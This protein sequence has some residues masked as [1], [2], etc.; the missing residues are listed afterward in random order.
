MQASGINGTVSS[1]ILIVDHSLDLGEQTSALTD[2]AQILQK[3]FPEVIVSSE[4]DSWKHLENGVDLLYLEYSVTDMKGILFLKKLSEHPNYSLLPTLFVSKTKAYDHRVNAFEIG[5]ADFITRPLDETHLVEMTR[6]QLQNRR[7]IFADGTVQ[8]G[9]LLFDPRTRSVLINSERIKLTDLEYKILRY[10]LVTPK[11]V[12]TRDE[13]CFQVWGDTV[14]NTGRL[15]TQLYNLKKKISQFN[16]KIKS[17]NKIGMR[18][19]A[20]QTTFYR[21]EK[22]PALRSLPQTV[23]LL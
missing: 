1:R 11:N 20:G 14:S 6:S 5:A 4:K 2:V 3:H 16:G 13:I 22:K 18:V 15:D 8:V 19:L 17:V 21:E 12:I 7:R 9:N 10:L 23:H